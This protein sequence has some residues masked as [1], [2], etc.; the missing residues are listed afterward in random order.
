MTTYEL[1]NIDDLLNILG[2]NGKLRMRYYERDR[3]VSVRSGDLETII[4][5]RKSTVIEN[6]WKLYE[7]VGY[8]LYVPTAAFIISSIRVLDYQT[9]DVCSKWIRALHKIIRDPQG[10]HFTT[11][12]EL[13]SEGIDMGIINKLT[14]DEVAKYG[15]ENVYR[16]IPLG[17][18]TIRSKTH[19]LAYDKRRG[20][21]IEERDGEKNRGSKLAKDDKDDYVYLWKMS[22][23]DPL[24]IIEYLSNVN[25]PVV[26]QTMFG[27]ELAR[28]ADAEIVLYCNGD[29]TSTFLQLAKEGKY[30]VTSDSSYVDEYIGN[31]S[32]DDPFI[33]GFLEIC[34]LYSEKWGENGENE[35]YESSGYGDIGLV[36][37]EA[38]LNHYGSID[39]WP[40]EIYHTMINIISDLA[41]MHKWMIPILE[42]QEVIETSLS[43]ALIYFPNKEVNSPDVPYD[44]FFSN[45]DAEAYLEK[46]V[47][48]VDD[49]LDNLVN[50]YEFVNMIDIESP[51][52][53][54][55]MEKSITYRRIFEMK[56]SQRMRSAAMATR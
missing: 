28:R 27:Y 24:S 14:V 48:H 22:S 20:Y 6:Y 56:R 29:S 16:M 40:S 4:Q 55:L 38:A 53:L 25:K 39:N 31:G 2:L 15:P 49:N 19:R 47:T 26:C 36:L 32:S 33:N 52:H 5:I 42:K 1:R 23:A 34:S 18:I 54:L 13:E 50:V 45:F 37:Y 9:M 21:Y 44:P 10:D 3:I 30:P 51:N 35:E 46:S 17:K 41:E 43:L 7:S 11:F 12:Q 8:Y